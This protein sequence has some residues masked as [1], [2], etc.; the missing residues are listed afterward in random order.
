MYL[1]LVL[2]IAQRK[3]IAAARFFVSVSPCGGKKSG[4]PAMA[5]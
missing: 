1:F 2:P 3:A 5:C 4:L